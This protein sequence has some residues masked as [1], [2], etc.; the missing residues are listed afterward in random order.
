MKKKT[1]ENILFQNGGI[2]NPSCFSIYKSTCTKLQRCLD[3]LIDAPLLILNLF[4]NT[5]EDKVLESKLQNPEK[6]KNVAKLL[7]SIL[8]VDW[9]GLFD[10][11]NVQ[12]IL[13]DAKTY[14][15]LMN[16]IFPQPILEAKFEASNQIYVNL[17]SEFTQWLNDQI[18]L[19]DEIGGKIKPNNL[20]QLMIATRGCHS[21]TSYQGNQ[22]V[23]NIMSNIVGGML[24]TRSKIFLQQ[25]FG[26]RLQLKTIQEIQNVLELSSTL[27]V[28]RFL[29]MFTLEDQIKDLY[30]TFLYMINLTSLWNEF[31]PWPIFLTL[32]IFFQVSMIMLT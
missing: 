30:G 26:N 10:Q 12:G 14:L 4:L 7:Q 3:G 29:S 1:L 32:Q 16:Q 22:D 18:L 13:N 20:D 27:H 23:W 19:V 21:S 31:R 9:N 2:K 8:V 5:H 24:N 11:E 28:I 25:Q 6:V 15:D 17:K